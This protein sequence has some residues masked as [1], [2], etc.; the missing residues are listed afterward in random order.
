MQRNTAGSEAPAHGGSCGESRRQYIA[1]IHSTSNG[2][3]IYVVNKMPINVWL[4]VSLAALKIG[5]SQDTIERRGVP[6]TERPVPFRIRYRYLV[7]DPG[8]DAIRAYYEPD[9]EALLLNSDELPRNSRPRFVPRF[10]QEAKL[11]RLVQS[12]SRQTSNRDFAS[13]DKEDNHEA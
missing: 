12:K 8:S 10:S 9:I 4:P 13:N 1:Q 6:W 5:R 11:R 2:E 3:N 7:L